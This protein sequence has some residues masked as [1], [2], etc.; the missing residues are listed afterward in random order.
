MMVMMEACLFSEQQCVFF[1]LLG[2]FAKRW[3]YNFTNTFHYTWFIKMSPC[4]NN[5]KMVSQQERIVF[6]P[7]IFSGK[8]LVLGR[9]SSF[10][11]CEM[12]CFRSLA[13]RLTQTQIMFEVV[14]RVTPKKKPKGWNLKILPQ[15]KKENASSKLQTYIFWGSICPHRSE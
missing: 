8:L 10:C 14:P 3:W 11:K 7:S 1:F 13:R 4:R 9:V 12:F 6:H 5:Q 2:V 15:L